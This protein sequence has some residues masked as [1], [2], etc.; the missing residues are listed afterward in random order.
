MTIAGAAREP[1]DRPATLRVWVFVCATLA[2]LCL[3]PIMGSESLTIRGVDVLIFVLLAAGLNVAVG[4]TGLVSMC[5]A[6]FFAVGGYAFGIL[7]RRIGLEGAAGFALA[8]SA[9]LAATLLLAASIA[10]I[11][12]RV[13]QAYFII[14]TLALGQLVYI[15][16]WKWH[17]V[18]GGDDGLI[19]I[20]PPTWLSTTAS[21][22][23]FALVVV[24]ISLAAL[25]QLR[26]SP[27]GRTFSAIRDNP[28]RTSFIGV[29]V[30]AFRFA[31]FVIA[32]GFAG[33]AGMLEAMFHR[34]MFPN[35]AS[36][37]T[38]ADALVVI[39]L[40][41]A[42]SFAGPILGAIVFKALT[43]VLPVITDY[44]EGA[45]G[46]VIL[47]VALVMPR[48]LHGLLRPFVSEGGR[49]HV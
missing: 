43:Y 44:W 29:P 1:V 12:V 24:L 49:H 3:L 37:I 47:L 33:I 15:V 40:G 14:L 6:A 45:L 36:F 42:Q 2:A 5:H 10:A 39:V 28:V 34:G 46:A 20:A 18:T 26:R 38:S 25:W 4:G 19:D 41:G 27:L 17:A 7:Q 35:S 13:T 32:A 30:N 48:G 11:V 21:F 22:Y 23:Y 8:S 16:I 9:A 31:S